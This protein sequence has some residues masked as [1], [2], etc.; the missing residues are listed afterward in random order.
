ML[1]PVSVTEF[2]LNGYTVT[3]V[4]LDPSVRRRAI[5]RVWEL[6]PAGFDRERPRTWRGVVPDSCHLKELGDRR[7][8]LKFR[9]CVRKESWLYDLMAG[10]HEVHSAVESLLGVGQVAAPKYF[11]GLYPVFPCVHERGKV[12]AGHL[13]THP[14]QVG[15][16]LYLDDVE[17]GGGGFHVWPGSHMP[18]GLA[19]YSLHADDPHP[20]CEQLVR[21]YQKTTRP[22]ELTGNAGTLILWHQRLIHAAG[23]NRGKKVRQAMLCDFSRPDLVDFQATPHGGDLWKHWNGDHSAKPLPVVG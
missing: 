18:V 2:F 3:R 8:R 15:G 7:G 9:E 11:R 4:N 21:D 10:N 1:P 6:L 14:F 19:H 13:D 16:V 22:V 17:L 20:E 23:L 5:D 12:E